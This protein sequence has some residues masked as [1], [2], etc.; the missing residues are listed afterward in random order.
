MRVLPGNGHIA[1]GTV[2]LEGVDLSTLTEKEMQR[3]RGQ[4]VALIPQDP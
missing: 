3:Q 2:E 1:S 4:T